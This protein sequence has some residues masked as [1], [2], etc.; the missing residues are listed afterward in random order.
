MLRLLPIIAVL[1]LLAAC[2]GDP[3]SNPAGR[4]RQVFNEHCASC[5]S[6]SPEVVIVGP[7][8]SGVA[9]RAAAA[10]EARSYIETAIIAPE[11]EIVKGFEN[12]MPRD[13]Q[14]KLTPQDL[15]ALVVFLLTLE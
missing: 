4:G 1:G 15:E 11:A 14:A 5:H 6:L 2:A 13:F 9:G 10:G 12:L 3:V 7:S 8:L